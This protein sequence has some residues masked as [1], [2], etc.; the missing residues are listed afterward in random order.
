MLTSKVGLQLDDGRAMSWAFTF[1]LPGHLAP[2]SAGA[3]R[4]D[5]RRGRCARS[6]TRRRRLCRSA[7]KGARGEFRCAR[8]GLGPRRSCDR[9]QIDFG[10]L[11]RRFPSGWRR[12][13]FSCPTATAR[14]PGIRLAAGTLDQRH[15]ILE[16]RP[17]RFRIQYAGAPT[18][19]G[20]SILKEVEVQVPDVSSA[21]VE[22]A[23][24]VWPR[25]T[26]ALRILDCEGREVFE[27]HRAD[28]R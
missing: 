11:E 7:A 25:G 19:H 22:A 20:S 16:A 8:E 18:D 1:Q 28:S 26:T 4:L 10:R 14:E 27:R 6:R 23:N 17:Q 5:R 15:S 12:G 21:I 3:D 9:P 13:W 24:L 2:A